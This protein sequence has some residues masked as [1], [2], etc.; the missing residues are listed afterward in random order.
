M[1]PNVEVSTNLGTRLEK[2]YFQSRKLSIYRVAKDTGVSKKMLCGVLSG[3]QRLPVREALML[4]RYFGE[5]EDFF[6]KLQLEDELRS[7]K[8]RL[9]HLS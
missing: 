2:E 3:R 5:A 6:A 9:Q 8:K 7:E 4:A 1:L